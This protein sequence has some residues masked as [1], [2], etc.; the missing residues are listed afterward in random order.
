MR[1]KGRRLPPKSP[2]PLYPRPLNPPN[3]GLLSSRREWLAS[4]PEKL[5][6]DFGLKVEVDGGNKNLEFKK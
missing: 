1:R 4:T 5:K 2:G 3:G 6:C